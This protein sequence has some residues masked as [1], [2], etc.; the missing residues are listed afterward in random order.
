M[1]QI[2]YAAIGDVGIDIYPNIGKQFPG[3]MALN[4]A[5]YASKAGAQ[6]SIIS[7]VGADKHAQIIT[8]FCDEKGISRDMLLEM[9]GVSDSVE[10]VLDENAV[11]K[12][13]N[14]NLGVLKQFRLNKTHQSFLGTQDIAVA[15]YLPEL[16]HLFN[17][18]STMSIPNTLKV[19]DFTDLS[20]HG[21]DQHILKEYTSSFDIF[22]LSID[23]KIDE[24]LHLFTSFI[25]S[26]NK[27][28]V[29]LLG[30]RGSVVILDGRQYTQ[31]AQSVAVRDTTG[32][33]D[34]YLATFLVE[35]FS[36][37][38]ITSAMMKATNSAS[39]TIQHHGAI[40]Q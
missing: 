19:G 28:G 40:T 18:F 31:K 13:Q 9:D 37:K 23:E 36:E 15:V 4:S 27:T 10:I 11:P 24:R 33:G 17:A 7:A 32:A 20:E 39:Q 25:R 29:A 22:T 1:T 14:W 26:Q 8:Q 12:Y 16:K 34:T 30:K 35:Y 3:G 6:A 38:N 21:G 2:K 5:F